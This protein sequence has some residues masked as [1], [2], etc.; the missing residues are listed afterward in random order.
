MGA[1]ESIAIQTKFNRSNDFYFVG[2]Q[3]SGNILF[4]ND[5]DRLK[6]DEIF[7]ELVGELGYK[8]QESRSST[9]SNGNSTTEHYTEYHHIPFLTLTVLLARPNNKQHKMSL[10]RGTYRWPFEF[11]LPENLPPSSAPNN[12]AYPHIKY[13]TRVVFDRPWYKRNITQTHLLT[14]SPRIN[15]LRRNDLQETFAFADQNRKRLRLQCC[16]FR[17]GIMPGQLLSFQ[18]NLHNP[19]QSKIKKIE[20]TFIQYRKTAVDSHNETIFSVDLPGLSEFDELHLQR[21]FDLLV[22]N[23]YLTPTYTFT[24]SYHGYSHHITV[25]YELKLKVKSHGIFTKIEVNIPVIVGTEAV[26]E[27]Q[28]QQQNY[29]MIMPTNI[30]PDF[31]ENNAPPSYETVVKNK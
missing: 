26:P 6:L 20:A 18:I 11:S 27:Q 30:S 4:Q 22:P 12:E 17:G 10:S 15:L 31:N 21:S 9:D 28:Q 16:L 13:Y 19:E 2:E 5:H 29:D 14:I 25:H 8:T 3:I 1:G 7:V 24:T 23:T